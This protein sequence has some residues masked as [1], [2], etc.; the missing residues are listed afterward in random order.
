MI[1][2][3]ILSDKEI[4]DI[5]N[6]WCSFGDTVHYKNPPKIFRRC[7][8]SFVYDSHDVPY[9]DIQMWYS[10]CNLGYKNKRLNEAM[11]KINERVR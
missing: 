8:G 2:S 5:D 3:D 6:Q 11:I 4:I 7:D 9:L 1:E 10:A